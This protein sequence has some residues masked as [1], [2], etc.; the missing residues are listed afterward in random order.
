MSGGSGGVIIIKSGT[1]SVAETSAVQE[2]IG[3]RKLA[4]LLAVLA[5]Q[6]EEWSFK[7]FKFVHGCILDAMEAYED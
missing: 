4:K 6:D 5:K 2:E 3:P 1:R 7:E